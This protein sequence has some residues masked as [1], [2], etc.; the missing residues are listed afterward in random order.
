MG[1]EHVHGRF[2]EAEADRATSRTNRHLVKVWK[3]RGVANR[4]VLP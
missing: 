4:R 2:P 3:A 1:I